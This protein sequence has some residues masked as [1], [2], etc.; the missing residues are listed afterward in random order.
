V[1]GVVLAYFRRSRGKLTHKRLTEELAKYETVSRKRSEAVLA[2]EAKKSHE[3]NI[4]AGSNDPRLIAKPEPYPEPEKK[5]AAAAASRAT[6]DWPDG[7]AHDWRD[8]LI[9]VCGPGLGDPAKEPGLTTTL[10]ELVRWRQAGCSWELDVIPIVAG[11]T[12]KA[13]GSPIRTWTVL[14]PDVMGARDRRLRPEDAPNRAPFQ[15]GTRLPDDWRPTPDD[16]AFALG[17]GLTEEETSRAADKFRDHWRAKAGGAGIRSDWSAEWRNWA[18]GDRDRR[19]ELAPGAGARGRGSGVEDFAS[20]IA[21][22]R[23]GG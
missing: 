5:E 6:D 14:S 8:A 15:D 9:A 18:R 3:N 23:G 19:K 10:A 4:P 2:R 12:A 22:R 1:K 13:R 20:I 7:K 21:R 11:R 16:H 17:E